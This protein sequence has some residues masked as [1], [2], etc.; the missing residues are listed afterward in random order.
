MIYRDFLPEALASGTFVPAPLAKIEGHGQ[1][2]LE[3]PKAG[4]SA[5][6]VVVTLT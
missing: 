4:I 2:G 1:L 3:N 6:K 5:A